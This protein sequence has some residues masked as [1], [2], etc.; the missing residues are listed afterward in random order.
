[1][2][3]DSQSRWV[4]PAALVGIFLFLTIPGITAATEFVVWNR[5]AMSLDQPGAFVGLASTADVNYYGP[6]PLVPDGG[7]VFSFAATLDTGASGCVVAAYMAQGRNLP[8]TGGTF[9]DV[10]IGG[11]EV[12]D[13]SQPTSVKMASVGIGAE[14]SETPS[15]FTSYGDYNLQVRQSD[16]QIDLGFFYDPVYI[17]VIGTPVLNMHVMHVQPNGQS[18][19][20]FV[21]GGLF[22]I[23]FCPVNYLETDLLASA[24]SSLNVCRSELALVRADNGAVLHVPLVYQ[25]FVANSP[26]P[27]VS[28]STNPMIPNVTL[29]RG[30]TPYT[31]DWLFDTGAAV[32]IVGRDMATS[33]GLLSQPVV[34]ETQVIGIGGEMRTINGYQVDSLNIPQIDG[35]SLLFQDIVVFVPGEGDL[36][37]DLPGIFGMNL[38]NSS[39][40][41]TSLEGDYLDYTTSVFSD[42]YVVPPNVLLPGDADGDGSVNGTDLNT[43]LSH[44]NQTG[45]DWIHGDFNHDG[46][47]NG[48]DLNALLSHYNQSLGAS[49]AAVPEPS[50]IVMMLVGVLS[51]FGTA[52]R[53]RKPQ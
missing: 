39:F 40:S 37:A 46:S 6:D 24:P 50:A 21:D 8:T 45:A 42:W 49:T 51:L 25:D 43:V 19:P 4:A 29:T 2:R 22:G 36:P 48:T 18:F 13:V 23:G 17:N 31:S 5:Q 14:N 34:A 7:N 9:S 52:I 44:Y 28:T 3:G 27:P 15:L 47:V 26:A 33:L 32:T 41:G 1:M 35:T 53:R 10:G 38:L 16:P 20:Y 11:I 12:F 30:S